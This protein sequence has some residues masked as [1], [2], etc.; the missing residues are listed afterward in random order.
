MPPVP[1][2]SRREGGGGWENLMPYYLVDAREGG[3]T[4]GVYSSCWGWGGDRMTGVVASPNDQS[5]AI[6]WPAGK[7]SH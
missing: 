5:V 7:G 3:V 4:K 2:L 1:Y 6:S